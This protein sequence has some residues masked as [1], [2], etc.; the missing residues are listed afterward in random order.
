[1]LI[2]SMYRRNVSTKYT[3]ACIVAAHTEVEINFKLYSMSDFK[4]LLR[5]IHLQQFFGVIKCVLSILGQIREVEILKYCQGSG[6]PHYRKRLPCKTPLTNPDY[7][8][9]NPVAAVDLRDW[10]LSII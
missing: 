6:G 2:I 9:E 8:P 4:R 1:M 7:G 10:V 5:I 3:Q